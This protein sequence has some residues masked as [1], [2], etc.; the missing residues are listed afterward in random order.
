MS[1]VKISLTGVVIIAAVT[2]ALLLLFSP[3][4]PAMLSLLEAKHCV[5]HLEPVPA[6]STESSKSTDLGCYETSEEA[7]SVANGDQPPS[8]TDPLSGTRWKLLAFANQV[9]PEQAEM[10]SNSKMVA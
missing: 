7:M 1:N 5:M 2:V 4:V 3:R 9:L 8:K 10:V 6:G